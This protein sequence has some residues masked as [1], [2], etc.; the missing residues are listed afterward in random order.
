ME[1]DFD[2]QNS[3]FSGGPPSDSQMYQQQQQ[4]LYQVCLILSLVFW[5]VATAGARAS[6]LVEQNFVSKI[7]WFY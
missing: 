3:T 4:P 6:Y 5:T 1:D 7:K 2:D